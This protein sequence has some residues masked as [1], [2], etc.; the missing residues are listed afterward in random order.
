M[1]RSKPNSLTIRCGGFR[2]AP[3]KKKKKTL[4]LCVILILRS[5]HINFLPRWYLHPLVMISILAL[6]SKI[7]LTALEGEA[8]G[9]ERHDMRI[10]PEES[11]HSFT[12]I[13]EGDASLDIQVLF[14]AR[15]TQLDTPT[16]R[17]NEWQQACQILSKYL[18]SCMTYIHKI[19]CGISL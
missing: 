17:H 5:P 15:T 18:L 12:V 3:G 9:C 7:S 19:R 4:W 2:R 14:Q 11:R 16:L 10:L 1:G 6:R 8:E 13:V